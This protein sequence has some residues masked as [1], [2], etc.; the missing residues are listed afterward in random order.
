MFSA[1]DGIFTNKQLNEIINMSLHA[2]Q[3]GFELHEALKK[4]LADKPD[5]TK[6]KIGAAH[7]RVKHLEKQCS[8]NSCSGKMELF[9]V[10]CS[11]REM[12][13]QGYFTK[14]ECTKCGKVEYS[15]QTLDEARKILMEGK[16]GT[17]K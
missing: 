12:K 13:K 6:S 17:S 2:N 15:R 1:W 5:S 11:D 8:A 3:N 10:C 9:S 4:D 7:K 14:W 16:N